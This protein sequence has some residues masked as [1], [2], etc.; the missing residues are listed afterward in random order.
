MNNN[1]SLIQQFC[2]YQEKVRTFSPITV[3]ISNALCR[4][5]ITFLHEQKVAD[6]KQAQAE[7]VLAWIA[8]RQNKDNAN[9]RTIEH[10]LCVLRSLYEYLIN[11]HHPCSDP[12]GCLPDFLC[13]QPEEQDYVSVDE[14]FQMLDTF[15]TNDV[16]EWRNYLIIALLWSTGLRSAELRALQWRD[17]NLDEGILLVR[18]GK[19]N[20]QRQ[21]FLND[22]ILNELR[23]YRSKILASER[24]TVFCSYPK[25]RRSV[26]T[27]VRISEKLLLEIIR[28]AARTAGIKRR[29][30]A[31]MLRHSFATHMYE[32]GVNIADIAEMM[33][34]RERTETTRYIHVSVAAAK[35]LLNKHASRSIKWRETQ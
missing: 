26:V 31:Q 7:D 17:I 30:T 15:N 11:F 6:I 28:T 3:K 14:V 8:L 12:C 16:I 5:W 1:E 25:N 24:T 32:A 23:E 21:F 35:Q 10:E 4:R 18:K 29:T 19:G 27:E 22:R 34:H 13:K 33:G 20:K 9:E 2:E